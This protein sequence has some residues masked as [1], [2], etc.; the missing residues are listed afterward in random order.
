MQYV[1]PVSPFLGLEIAATVS[2][3]VTRDLNIKTDP[4]STN[5]KNYWHNETTV[6]INYLT[7]INTCSVL[8]F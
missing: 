3:A 2:T 4:D 1:L 6:P 8:G 7:F 5:T